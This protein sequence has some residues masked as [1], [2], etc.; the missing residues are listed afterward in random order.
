MFRP[1]SFRR[2]PHSHYHLQFLPLKTVEISENKWKITIHLP[3]AFNRLSSGL[4]RDLYAFKRWRGKGGGKGI[5]VGR[6]NRSGSECSVRTV[7][8]IIIIMSY[9]QT[10]R[11]IGLSLI[12]LAFPFPFPFPAFVF[13]FTSFLF[14]LVT[15]SPSLNSSRASKK[16]ARSSL[17]FWKR[18][19]D[20]LAFFCFHLSPLHPPSLPWA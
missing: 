9:D 3:V 4:L 16:G 14:I 19:W 2:V 11:V 1:R 7:R 8:T 15:G 17:F 18:S 12:V 6:S 10:Y 5:V 13:F 20:F